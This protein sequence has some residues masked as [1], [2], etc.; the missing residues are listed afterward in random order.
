[1]ATMH[2]DQPIDVKPW[3]NTHFL[4]LRPHMRIVRQGRQR[5][6]SARPLPHLL[7]GGGAVCRG[8]QD[9]PRL[10]AAVVRVVGDRPA[11]GL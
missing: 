3:L 6:R 7:R 11:S 1:M 9:V 10:P 8:E 4:P 2:A 5:R